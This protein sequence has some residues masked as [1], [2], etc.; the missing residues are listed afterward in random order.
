MV[1]HLLYLLY[2]FPIPLDLHSAHKLA[3]RI[4]CT[5]ERPPPGASA[6]ESRKI[7]SEAAARMIH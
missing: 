5:K 4:G 7:R 3:L 6:K 1:G 2:D